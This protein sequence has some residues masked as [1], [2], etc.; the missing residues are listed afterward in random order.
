MK[1]PIITALLVGTGLTLV[2]APVGAVWV[3]DGVPVTVTSLG[4]WDP[5]IVP[6]GAGGVIIAWS[7]YTAPPN[8]HIFAQRLDAT[9]A[10]LWPA[11]GVRVCTE[12]SYQNYPQLVSDGAGGAII[13][14][15]DYRN[16]NADIYVQHVDAS[17]I[18]LWAA[19][20]IPVCTA[21]NDQYLYHP[22]QLVSDGAG[23]VIIA[24][25]DARSTEWDI[26]ALRFDAAGT[27]LG[28]ADGTPICTATSYQE[29]PG[30][31]SDGSGGAIIAWYDARNGGSQRDLYAQRV[32]A[33]VVP[34]WAANGVAV[35]N[36]SPYTN[37]HP[38][39]VSDGAGGAIIAW[40][41]ER[42]GD[43]QV[44]ARRISADGT[45]MWTADGV[46]LCTA[47]GRQAYPQLVSDGAG[48]AIAA[49]EDRRSG[50]S[51]IYAQRVDPFGT[52]LWTLD[53]VALCTND[54]VQ[55]TP[56][57][58]SDGAGGAIIAWED[59]RS[60]NADIYGRGIDTN[61]TPLWTAD[62]VDVCTAADAQYQT[63]VAS[64]GAGGAIMAWIDLRRNGYTK[65]VYAQRLTAPPNAVAI[66]FFDATA[67]SGIVTVRA[68]FRSDLGVEA[69]DVY[70]GLGTDDYPLTV[71]EHV[72]DVRG[73]RFEYVDRNVTLGQTY[74]YQIGVIDA[75]GTFL[76]PIETV[77][78][79][80]IVGGLAQNRPNPFNPTTTIEYT[81]SERS[82]ALLVIY[83]IAGALVARLDQGVQDAGTHTVE[84]H[85][86]DAHGAPVVGGVYFYR[87]EGV[88]SVGSKKMVLLK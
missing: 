87:L 27:P 44:Y 83:D 71:I 18:P 52:S 62:G 23:G 69:V 78:V 25:E 2:S 29:H 55:V 8:Y 32:D 79:G 45:P 14:W 4:Q 38:Q 76:S 77:S 65:D 10:R 68:T 15:G 82:P 11:N 19:N 80:A 88:K 40:D 24:W 17:G 36:W 48:G 5:E 53:G 42:G 39:L 70:R 64:D 66:R 6:D 85:G 81:L 13:A 7:E 56:Q 57:L 34:L 20:G 49:W 33:S 9:G 75:D 59:L 26:Y 37:A 31:T 47:P 43:F 73:D 67:K 22:T 74:R 51:D 72:D 21:P 30:L 60:G 16:G 86:R 54:S 1:R 50:N 61:G 41:D 63:R 12:A 46:G 35:S 3:P 58:V 84:W 28:T